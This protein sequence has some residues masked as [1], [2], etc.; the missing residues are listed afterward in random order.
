MQIS[1]HPFSEFELN[2]GWHDALI[3]RWQFPA[4]CR[5]PLALNE[6]FDPCGC[7]YDTHQ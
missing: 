5:I 2:D 1:R 6:T 4:D 3:A 7:I